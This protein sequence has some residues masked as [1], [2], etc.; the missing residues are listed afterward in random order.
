VV[1]VVVVMVVV[2]VVVECWRRIKVILKR[3]WWLNVGDASK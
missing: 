1:V 3:L 2:V